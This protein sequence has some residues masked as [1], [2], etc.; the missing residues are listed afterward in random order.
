MKRLLLISVIFSFPSFLCARYCKILIPDTL[1]KQRIDY[2]DIMANIQGD[3]CDLTKISQSNDVYL[4]FYDYVDPEDTTNYYCK[5]HNTFYFYNR[6]GDTITRTGFENN[7]LRA[8][9]PIVQV[10]LN[11][12]PNNTLQKPFVG[13]CEWEHSVTKS[14]EGKIKMTQSGF[15]RLLLPNHTYD[16]TFLVHSVIDY[17]DVSSVIH[18]YRFYVPL[19]P[20]PLFESE[21]GYLQG[22]LAYQVSYYFPITDE[23]LEKYIVEEPP[24]ELNEWND[25]NAQKGILKYGPSPVMDILNIRYKLTEAQEVNLRLFDESG[26]LLYSQFLSEEEGVHE[27]KINMNSLKSGVYIL[28]ISMGNQVETHLVLKL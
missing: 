3:S 12:F 22:E 13:K 23:L 24:I 10:V 20:Y 1:I 19:F 7:L 8:H 9:Y 5:E 17:K 11:K 16:S 28:Y 27:A 25:E 14:I 26:N 21:E 15:Y 18:N 6:N 4:V 2:V